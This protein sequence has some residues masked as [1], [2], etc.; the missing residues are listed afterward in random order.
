[1]LGRNIHHILVTEEGK[2]KNVL[3]SHD[4]ML[5]QGKSPLSL[6]RHIEQQQTLDD[7]TV[8]QKRIGDLLPLLM[9]EGARAPAILREWLPS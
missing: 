3:T 9:R 8:A 2:P 5:L 7:L 4:P 1:M 6:A